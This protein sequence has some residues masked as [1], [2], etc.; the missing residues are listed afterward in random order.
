MLFATVYYIIELKRDTRCD[1]PSILY[2]YNYN[3]F[4]KTSN[5]HTPPSSLDP[6]WR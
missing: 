1:L 2:V 3:M 6:V 4:I 5:S